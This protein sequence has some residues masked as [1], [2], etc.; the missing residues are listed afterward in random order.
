MG[1]GNLYFNNN[2]ID[3]NLVEPSTSSEANNV[4]VAQEVATVEPFTVVEP[5]RAKETCHEPRTPD[6]LTVFARSKLE[7]ILY[8]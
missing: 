3:A 4:V 8:S 5:S 7:G 6:R 2:P 1:R